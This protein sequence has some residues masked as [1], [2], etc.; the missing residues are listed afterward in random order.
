MSLIFDLPAGINI[1]G[2]IQ[3]EVEL[4]RTNGVAEKVFTKRIP[5]QP[6]TWQARILSVAI[7]RVGDIFIGQG[8]REEYLKN[9]DFEIPAVILDMTL[10][11]LNTC[12]VEIHRKVW[13]HLLKKQDFICKFCTKQLKGEVDLNNIDYSKEDKEFL[14][15]EPDLSKIL[16]YLKYGFDVAETRELGSRDDYQVFRGQLVNK[17]TYRPPTV[18]DAIRNEPYAEDEIMFWRRLA[19]DCL[20]K[21]EIVENGDTPE[22]KVVD[23]LPSSANTFLG[24]NLYE[25]YLDAA[26]LLNV[27]EE[28]QEFIPTLPFYYEETCPCDKRLKVPYVME[29]SGFFSA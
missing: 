26:D 24:L 23:E 16:V 22:E 10:A 2:K 25:N 4:L 12:I 3:K 14:K 21:M 7:K 28:M 29:A 18:R 1:G 20:Q 9:G 6:Y 17:L 19:F 11:D 15:T 13:K 5:E 27:R 8:C